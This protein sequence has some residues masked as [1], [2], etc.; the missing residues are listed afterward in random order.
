MESTDDAVTGH[1][2]PFARRLLYV[3]YT[4]HEVSPEERKDV[5][6]L[7]SMVRLYSVA[8]VHTQS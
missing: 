2:D 5:M 8:D 6:R 3:V 4:S 1:C 7:Y